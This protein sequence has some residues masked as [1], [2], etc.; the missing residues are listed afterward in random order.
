MMLRPSGLLALF[1]GLVCSLLVLQVIV[2]TR[3]GESADTW[4]PAG[5]FLAVG[6]QADSARWHAGPGDSDGHGP[7]SLVASNEE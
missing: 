6:V 5:S 2:T 4:P 7:I 3:A 1:L